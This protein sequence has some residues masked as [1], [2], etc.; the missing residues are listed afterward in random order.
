LA[1]LVAGFLPG[2]FLPLLP[3][4]AD[5]FSD[6]DD[7]AAFV[8]AANANADGAAAVV[9]DGVTGVPNSVDK[10]GG[11]DVVADAA[12]E[13][14]DVAA[15]TAET[16]DGVAAIAGCDS[17]AADAAGESD[18]AGVV[19]DAVIEA[20]SVTV[21]VADGDGEATLTAFADL[22]LRLGRVPAG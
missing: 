6:A 13:A 21:A 20:G 10:T 7:G 22:R 15:A 8:A 11:A 4:G 18:G 19:A 12:G 3:G 5:V 2:D 14:D 9:D 16:D 17:D 1:W